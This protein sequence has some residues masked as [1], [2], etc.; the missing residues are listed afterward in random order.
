VILPKPKPIQTR[1]V[2]AIAVLG[3]GGEACGFMLVR[4]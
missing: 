1:I 3:N 2:S 4:A